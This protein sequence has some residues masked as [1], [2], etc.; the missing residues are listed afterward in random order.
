MFNNLCCYQNP[1]HCTVAI[2]TKNLN[3]RQFLLLA[4][5]ITITGMEKINLHIRQHAQ[6]ARYALCNINEV[7]DDSD[8]CTSFCSSNH[9][10]E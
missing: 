10:P 5:G 4:V 8:L 3:R 7:A 1:P 2:W 6:F 9:S